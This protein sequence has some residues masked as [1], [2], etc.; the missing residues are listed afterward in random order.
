VR[1]GLTGIEVWRG[2][3]RVGDT[4]DVGSGFEAWRQRML[5]GR[6]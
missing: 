6:G 5:W 1:R 3:S 2:P 4:R